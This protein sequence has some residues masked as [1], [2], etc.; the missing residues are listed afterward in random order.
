[1][2]VVVCLITVGEDV[3][4]SGYELDFV[5]RVE[6]LQLF[7]IVDDLAFSELL[8]CEVRQSRGNS[9]HREAFRA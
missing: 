9:T 6:E 4:E 8:D 7:V 5:I 2:F 3:D 1:M